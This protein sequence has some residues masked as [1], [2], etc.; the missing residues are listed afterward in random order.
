MHFFTLALRVLPFEGVIRGVQHTIMNNQ[1]PDIDHL[2]SLYLSRRASDSQKQALEEWLASSS[3]NAATFHRLE[4]IWAM[5]FPVEHDPKMDNVRDRIWNKATGDKEKHVHTDATGMADTVKVVRF[6]WIKAAAM[7]LIFIAGAWLFSQMN[8][9]EE[10]PIPKAVAWVE[11]VNPSG[12]RSS[13][14]LP[15][16]TKV[17]L[18]VASQ[19]SFPEEF[20]D[21]LRQ[22]KLIGEAFFEVS[23]DA[24]KPFVVEAE[25]FST[26]VLGTSFN[27][28][29]YPEDPEIKVALL[30]GKVQVRNNGSS[31]VQTSVLSPGEGLLAPKDN[32]AFSKYEFQYENT[33]GWKE[34]ILVF[35]GSDFERFRK[36]IEKWYGVEVEVKGRMP[37]SWNMRARYQR[38]SLQHVLE[39]I[40]FNKNMKYEIQDKTV[41][42]TF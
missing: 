42:V 5:P 13:H 36:T 10:I 23:K 19:L 17:W 41:V 32:S 3:E 25:G 18:N 31:Q 34:G 24:T 28:R 27:V 37:G 15:D 16:G 33:F 26:L 35:D 7:F 39:D 2:I 38:A 40:S 22:V 12:Q 30:E 8:K 9:T 14:L 6:P 4:K 11:K 1:Q 29:A 21:T 20:S